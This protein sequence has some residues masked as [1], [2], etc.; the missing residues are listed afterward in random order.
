VQTDG[1]RCS[2]WLRISGLGNLALI[3]TNVAM[4]LHDYRI[5]QTTFFAHSAVVAAFSALNHWIKTRDAK[6]PRDT[7]GA[8]PYE[9]P[10][11]S[12][13]A[14]IYLFVW[15]GTIAITG[16]IERTPATTVLCIILLL[17]AGL[18]RLRNRRS[19]SRIYISLGLGT[20]AVFAALTLLPTKWCDGKVVTHDSCH[21]STVSPLQMRAGFAVSGLASVAIFLYTEFKGRWPRE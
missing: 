19:A 13:L 3:G 4:G 1:E 21:T 6:L 18:F 9:T 12:V 5:I 11:I 15:A 17:A 8:A 14:V 2:A 20:A 16:G 7:P 10:L